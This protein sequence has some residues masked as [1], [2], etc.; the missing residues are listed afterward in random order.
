MKL[1]TGKWPCEIAEVKFPL[2]DL[3][4]LWV[5]LFI[6]VLPQLWSIVDK[7]QESEWVWG[8]SLC[9]CVCVSMCIYWV[10]GCNVKISSSLFKN[11]QPP[12]LISPDLMSQISAAV[13]L[14][15]Q[16]TCEAVVSAE[17]R[18]SINSS[19]WIIHKP[20]ECWRVEELKP[21]VCVR[22]V[23]THAHNEKL[24]QN[25]QMEKKKESAGATVCFHLKQSFILA[26][27]QH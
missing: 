18:F 10:W 5:S 25:S 12:F 6:V 19:F 14:K 11:S 22:A 9:V 3:L 7:C 20:K 17:D 27:A 21:S 26:R 1:H 8:C 16:N 13:A 4:L 23:D 15:V 2:Q 24:P